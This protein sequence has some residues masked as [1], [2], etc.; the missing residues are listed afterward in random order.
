[1]K[2]V[3][4]KDFDALIKEGVSIVD[5]YA[6][7]CMPCRMFASILED[8]E[9]ELGEKVNILKVDVDKNEILS[10]RYGVMSIPTILIFK[11]GEMV[12]RH[13]GV[14]QKDDCVNTV[15]KYLN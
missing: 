9:D 6:S 13:V 15:K 4:E 10:R 7:W 14:W 12:E 8:I 3:S 2:E 1:M 5:F 11:D